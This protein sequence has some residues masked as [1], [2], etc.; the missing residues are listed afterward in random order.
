LPGGTLIGSL[1]VGTTGSSSSPSS[2]SVSLLG[3]VRLPKGAVGRCGSPIGF[4]G[5]TGELRAGGTAT[6]GVEA[7]DSTAEVD[8]DA[9][10]AVEGFGGS[11]ILCGEVKDEERREVAPQP[12]PIARRSC[13]K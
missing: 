8:A 5:R 3:P 2:R 9:M 7:L 4:E 13:S 1:F 10:V 12:C 11:A 6:A